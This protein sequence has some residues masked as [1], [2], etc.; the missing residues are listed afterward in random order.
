M[1]NIKLI[2]EEKYMLHPMP[3][4]TSLRIVC[5]CGTVIDEGGTHS[6]G[7]TT[8]TCSVCAEREQS[9][10]PQG[11]HTLEITKNIT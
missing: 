11:E 9:K 6:D 1:Y 10:I 4:Q 3:S 8:G 7:Q 2:R 5:K